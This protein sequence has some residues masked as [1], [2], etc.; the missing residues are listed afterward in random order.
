MAAI[1]VSYQ[2]AY[3][4]GKHGNLQEFVNSGKL[5]EFFIYQMEFFCDAL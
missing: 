5:W 3:N 1:V 2:G 4:S